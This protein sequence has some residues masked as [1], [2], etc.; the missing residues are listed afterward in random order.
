MN[1]IGN[2]ASQA[3][4]NGA[5]AVTFE[6]RD[7]GMEVFPVSGSYGVSI[8]FYL[9]RSSPE[10]ETL[11]EDLY[12]LTRKGQ[13]LKVD[14]RRYELRCR[15]YESFMENAFRLEWKSINP[16]SKA[17]NPKTCQQSGNA[18]NKRGTATIKINR[19]GI[20]ASRAGTLRKTQ[21]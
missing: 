3:I 2:I 9:E 19:A 17:R 15:M 14:R 20:I 12:Q 5:K 6:Y 7:G 21:V 11:P 13:C 8:G 1:F 10:M 4:R 18:K 16:I